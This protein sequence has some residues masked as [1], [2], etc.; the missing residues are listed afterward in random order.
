MRALEEAPIDG[1][2][3]Y[4]IDPLNEQRKSQ[5]QDYVAT[6]YTHDSYG[7][8][9]S[10]Q[11]NLYSASTDL[12]SSPGAAPK[13]QL[14]KTSYTYG[15]GGLLSSMTDPRGN[16]T[17]YTYQT[18]TPYLVKVDAPAGTG[19]SSRRVTT[20]TYNPDGTVASRTDPKGNK[21]TYTYDGLG[22]LTEADYGMQD[23][24]AD[25]K[26]TYS[27]DADGDRTSMTDSAGSSSY[28]YDESDRLA[29]QSRTQDGVTKSTSYSYYTN[30]LLSSK[31]SYTGQTLDQ[32]TSYSY[33]SAGRLVS[34]TDPNDGGGTVGYTYDSDSQLI[35]LTF[36]SGA[37]KHLSYDQVGN[38]SQITLQAP[39]GGLVLQSYSYDYGIDQQGNLTSSYWNGFVRSTT[40]LDG[41]QTSY[42][43]DDLG[44]LVSAVRTGT[45]PYSQS[46]TYDA[47]DNLTSITKDGVTTTATYD[48]ANQLVS[49]SS[50][51]TY[52]YDPNGNQV[53]NGGNTFSYDAAN[54]MAST[55]GGVSYTYDGDGNR[56]SRTV[57]SSRIDYWYEGSE[58]DQETG[59]QNATYQRDPGGHLLSESSG[60]SVHDYNTDRLG[61][62]TGLMS[63]D[64]HLTDSYG[65]TPWGEDNGTIGSTY[66]PYR[67]T[68]TYLDSD[69]GLYQMG[70]RYY[71]PDAGRFTQIDPLSCS[72]THVQRYSYADDNPVNATDPTG[73]RTTWRCGWV[74]VWEA[75]GF[76]PYRYWA[77]TVA[78]FIGA[79]LITLPLGPFIASLSV[80][81]RAF[82]LT[83]SWIGAGIGGWFCERWCR[84]HS[85]SMRFYYNP[86]G[87]YRCWEVSG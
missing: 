60:G 65:Y 24:V 4:T 8:T 64:G 38:V 68:S 70:A 63:T 47:D 2:V 31:Q 18:N 12:D 5:G 73:E 80:G 11:V 54:H 29:S 6:V 52:S 27:Y 1:D 43:Y 44:R 7:N 23:G 13:S 22:R 61:T 79:G 45:N 41:S 34:Q 39:N 72:V 86:N 33:D 35:K 58:M 28:T 36:P 59:P 21:T 84:E 87:V 48:N 10:E 30:G 25:F 77:C 32:T 50:G 53:A 66:N 9:T 62:V 67:Y 42:S 81:L 83:A 74:T 82:A 26:V 76:N 15:A 17:Y 19:E 71:E 16:T 49:D 69:T 78:C 56:T 75:W 37:T 46:Y 40:E 51:T 20:I 57:G 55:N 3:T 14:R 85:Y